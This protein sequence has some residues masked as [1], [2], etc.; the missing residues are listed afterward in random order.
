MRT[1]ELTEDQVDFLKACMEFISDLPTGFEAINSY[2]D[3]DLELDAWVLSK[4]I[5]SIL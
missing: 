3:E 5:N 4:E 1:I 2:L